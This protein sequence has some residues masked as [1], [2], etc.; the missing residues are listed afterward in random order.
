MRSKHSI[1]ELIEFAQ[2][3][4]G[5]CLSTRYEG[6]HKKYHWKCEFDHEWFSEANTVIN[7]NNWCNTCARINSGNK[8]RKNVDYLHDLAKRNNGKSLS[9][10]YKIANTKYDWECRDGHQWSATANNIQR[11]KWCPICKESHGERKIR[12]MLDKYNINYIRQHYFKNCYGNSIKKKPLI[13][14]FFLP[15]INTCIEYDGEQHFKPVLNF[16]GLNGYK[17]CIFNDKIKN[18]YTKNNNIQL[19]RIPYYE[20]S[21]I[22]NYIS[23]LALTS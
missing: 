2:K 12:E 5:F 20:F 6:I 3:K 10:F 17:K 16:G 19:I 13:F 7:L 14:D 11:G 18:E 9:N 1:E 8:R 21:L 23:K 4:G 15:E 22:E